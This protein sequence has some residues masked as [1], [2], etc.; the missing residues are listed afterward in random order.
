MKIF[1]SQP[2][3]NKSYEQIKFERQNLVRKL[4]QKGHEVLE[5]VFDDYDELKSPIFYLA[6]SIEIL[7]KA[8]RVVF[9]EGWETARGCRIEYEISRKYG[10]EILILEEEFY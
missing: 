9:M 7:D 4:E 2:M 8:D 1:I 10:K 6:K 3:G 5:T